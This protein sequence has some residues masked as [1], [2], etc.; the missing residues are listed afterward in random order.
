MTK[1]FLAPTLWVAA[2]LVGCGGND[3]AAPVA[4]ADDYAQ[5]ETPADAMVQA[6]AEAKAASK[7]RYGN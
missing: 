1:W 4:T 6:Q 7:E 3:T 2:C 5:Y